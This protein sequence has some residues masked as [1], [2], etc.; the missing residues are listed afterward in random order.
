MVIPLL[1]RLGIGVGLATLL[2]IVVGLF[3][4]RTY[5]IERSIVITAS[6]ERIHES[7]DNLDHWP[8]WSPWCKADPDLKITLGDVTRGKGAHQSWISKASVGELTFTR[9]DPAWGVGFDMVFDKGPTE[10][11]CTMRYAPADSGGIEVTWVMTGDNGYNLLARYFGL[12]MDPLMGS[13]FDEGLVRL[14]LVAEEAPA[15]DGGLG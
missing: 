4:P 6:Q 5:T 13:M 1:K 12:L 10:A 7:C 3:L 2:V 8:R 15:E 14:K 11:I 9:S